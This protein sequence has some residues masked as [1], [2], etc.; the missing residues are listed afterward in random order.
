MAKHRNHRHSR[1]AEKKY[2]PYHML[3]FFLSVVTLVSVIVLLQKV[4]SA[5]VWKVGILGI[6]SFTGLVF[7][8][9][10]LRRSKK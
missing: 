8:L 1:T 4:N 10:L 7:C 3:L 9:L 5:P 2:V 6:A